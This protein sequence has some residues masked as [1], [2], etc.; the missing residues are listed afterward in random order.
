MAKFKGVIKFRPQIFQKKLDQLSKDKRNKVREEVILGA[1]AIAGTAKKLVNQVQSKGVPIT[2]GGVQHYPSLEGYPPNTDTGAL[3][4]SI[5]A[6]HRGDSSEV[7]AG[8]KNHVDYAAYLEFGTIRTGER[9]F[10]RPAYKQ[11]IKSISKKIRDAFK[12]K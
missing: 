12:D 8:R 10:M 11:N 9:P 7:I 4:Q 3:A 2:R 5:R 6:E 1:E